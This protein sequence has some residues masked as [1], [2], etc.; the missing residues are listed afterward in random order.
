MNI[1]F[2]TDWHGH[3]FS[4]PKESVDILVALGDFDWKQIKRLD[5]LFTCPKLGLLGNHDRWDTYKNTDFVHMH[6]HVLD[7]NG[8]KFAGFDGSPRYNFK[9]APQFEEGDVEDFT[10]GLFGVD[11][12]LAHAN[13]MLTPSF[14]KTDAHRGF[15]A[16]TKYI[17]S[18]KP[19][20]F[21]HGH[22][23]VEE[24]TRRGKTIIQSVYPTFLLKR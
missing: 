23:H 4:L 22:N 21:F 20:Y 16:F 19:A 12:F 15:Q 5:Q 17:D 18:K 14:D 2:V 10:S 24:T 1:L 8:I 9:D 6:T 13:P 3:D 11:I 7:V